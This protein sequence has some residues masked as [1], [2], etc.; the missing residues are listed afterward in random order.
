MRSRLAPKPF[1]RARP[2]HSPTPASAPRQPAW[3]A[4]MTRACGVG[5]Q[6]R[7]AVGG[8]DAERDARTVGD[9]GVGLRSLRPVAQTLVD[10]R[11]VGAVNLVG[12]RQTVRRGAQR[13]GDARAVFQHR[14]RSSLEPMPQLRLA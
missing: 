5:E 14:A 8:A 12:R 4:P 11:D 2:S 3:A 9:D 6:D 13:G 7:P 1:H 10:D